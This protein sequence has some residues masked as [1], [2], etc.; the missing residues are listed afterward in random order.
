MFMF[1]PH[2]TINKISIAQY[3]NQCNQI[4][5]NKI[6]LKHITQTRESLRTNV[7]NHSR[8]AKASHLTFRTIRVA[9]KPAVVFPEPFA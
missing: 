9:R 6:I 2:L 4:T 7:L 3:K 5:S 1:I 8:G